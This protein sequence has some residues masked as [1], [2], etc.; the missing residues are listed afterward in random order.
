MTNPRGEQV[1]CEG[2]GLRD[3]TRRLVDGSEVVDLDLSTVVEDLEH[4]VEQDRPGGHDNHFEKG[5][6]IF[7]RKLLSFFN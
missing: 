3:G 2:Q 6:N 5:R 7:H 4:V 1:A